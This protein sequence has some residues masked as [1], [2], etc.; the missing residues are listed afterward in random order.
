MAQ[1]TP[2]LEE[3]F[4]GKLLSLGQTNRREEG[5][6]AENSPAIKAQ[7]KE[8][9]RKDQAT[10]AGSGPR[11]SAGKKGGQQATTIPNRELFSDGQVVGEGRKAGDAEPQPR[12]Q[13]TPPQMVEWRTVVGRKGKP[14]PC[15]NETSPH[16]SRTGR[17]AEQ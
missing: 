14:P 8:R 10:H 12:T 2:M 3:W 5:S 16:R 4:R 7:K 17:T 6:E 1:I 15:R 9:R 11:N 13:G